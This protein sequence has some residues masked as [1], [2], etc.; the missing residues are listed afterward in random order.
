MEYRAFFFAAVPLREDNANDFRFLFVV[1]GSAASV[2]PISTSD[3]DVVDTSSCKDIKQYI[4][5]I[6]ACG[7]MW[8]IVLM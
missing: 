2:G 8:K 6:V 4:S 1:S 7:T 5:N 3:M